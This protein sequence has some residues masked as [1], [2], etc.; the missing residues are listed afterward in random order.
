MAATSN[1]FNIVA[2]YPDGLY[3]QTEPGHESGMSGFELKPFPVVAFQDAYGNF[4]PTVP[5][6]PPVKASL[7][8]N[9]G[10]STL[11][12]GGRFPCV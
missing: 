8:N 2:G 3:M 1:A 4:D 6:T 12:Y 5:K 9:A 7:L 10:D 11:L